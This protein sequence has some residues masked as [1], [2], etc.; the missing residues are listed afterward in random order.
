V[1][2]DLAREQDELARA[3]LLVAQQR[4]NLEITRVFSNILWERHFGPFLAQVAALPDSDCG[5]IADAPGT[6]GEPDATAAKK[7]CYARLG[8]RIRALPEFKALHARV[9]D[10]MRKSS[11]FKIKV[12]DLRGLTVYASDHAQVGEDKSRN[13]GWRGAMAGTARSEL[14]HRDRFSAFE[15][16]VENRDLISS[17]VPV[18]DPRSSALVGVF[19]VYS[20]VTPMLRQ[21]R[22]SSLRIAQ[23][24]HENQQRLAQVWGRNLRVVDGMSTRGPAVVISLLAVLFMA[25]TVLVRRAG[26]IV[27]QQE[28]EREAHAEAL[29][30]ENAALAENARLRE[31]VERMSRHDLK[32]PLNSIIGVARLLHDDAALRPEQRE[33]LSIAERAGYRLLEMVNLSLDLSRMELGTYAFRPQAVDLAEVMRRVLLDLRAPAEAAGVRVQLQCDSPGPVYARA[34]ELLCYCMFANLVKNAIEAS[35]PR[36]CVRITIDSGDPL[37]LRIHNAGEVPA[38]AAARFFE[39][40]ASVGKSGGTGLGA[41]SARLMARV[42]RGELSMRTG[43]EGTELTVTLPA[44]GAEPLPLVPPPPPPS[45][46]FRPG[47]PEVLLPSAVRRVLIVDDD[48]YNLLLMMRYLPSPPFVLDTA[49]SG[50]A[51]IAAMERDWA[52][53]VLLDTELP[54]LDGC[55]VAAWI[56]TR[57]REQQRP[58]C[59]I[60]MMSSHGDDVASA[61][62]LAAGSDRYLAKPFTREALLALLQEL[63]QADA[64]PPAPV[65]GLSA[66]AAP[67]LPSQ[68][69][70]RVDPRLRPDVPAF[71]G[72]RLRLADA[73]AGALQAGQRAE[74]HRLAHQAAGGLALYGFDWAARQS[75]HICERAAEGDAQVLQAEIERLR[76]HLQSVRVAEEDPARQ[77]PGPALDREGAAA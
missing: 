21:I 48:E 17:Y 77:D 58:P 72:S 29:R 31:D 43:E 13:A 56:R 18:H 45:A 6:D 22:D 8:E 24:S 5:A 16:V 60:V 40:Y 71:L 61:R 53:I 52:D 50:P 65:Q 73:M 42:Q 23:A 14:T 30:R 20:D 26:A 75:C 10:A 44:L 55:A 28:Q 12:F 63:Q 76:E 34:E 59:R 32:T 49:G 35:P 62:A 3:D 19:E 74:L 47:P 51:A 4:A 25:L 68:A 64:A 7:D 67:P 69:P 41:Y 66:I 36:A 2:D 54:G 11:V 39:K 15:G 70:V 1:Q 37:R 27:G 33:L 38:A 57:E 46:E 9:S